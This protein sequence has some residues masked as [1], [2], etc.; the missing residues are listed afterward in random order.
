MESLSSDKRQK[1]IAFLLQVRDAVANLEQW[2]ASI[3]SEDDYY[4]SPEGMKTLAASCML[5]EAVGESF[6][7]IDKLTDGRLLK[8]C[9][10]IPWEDVIGIRNH[11]V[12]G[13]FDIDAAIVFNTIKNDLP[14]LKEAVNFL[15]DRVSSL[16]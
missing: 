8:E 13:Y 7:R 14:T 6:K 9:D 16:I 15:L 1:V 11:I 2:N 4:T 3:T 10:E 12:H 5:I